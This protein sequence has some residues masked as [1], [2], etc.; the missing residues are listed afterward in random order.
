[1]LVILD[2]EAEPLSQA[3]CLLTNA[4]DR[5][6]QV[7]CSGR[8]LNPHWQPFLTNCRV[9]YFATAASNHSNGC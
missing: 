3:V 2:E 9:P 8:E 1:V 7:W 5:K 4:S 6:Q